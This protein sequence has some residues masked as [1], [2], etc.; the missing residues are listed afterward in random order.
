MTSKKTP[1]KAL[2]GLAGEFHVLAQLAERGLVG[3]LT[4]GHTKGVDIVVTNPRT[5]SMRRVEVK[6]R[7][8][9]LGSETLF[10]PRPFY[11][12]QMSAKHER[13]KDRE[14]VYCLVALDDPASRPRFFLVPAEEVAK[15]V[16][17]EHRKWLRAHPRAKTNDIR[18]MRIDVSDPSGYEDNWSLFH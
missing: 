7:R 14:L 6:T 2:T 13:I 17:W 11:S 9:N 12:W 10:G 5:G 1:D 3:A 16:R 18:R 4:L 8:N 15:Y